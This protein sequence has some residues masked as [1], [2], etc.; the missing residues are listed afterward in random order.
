MSYLGLPDSMRD[1]NDSEL[2]ALDEWLHPW[3]SQPDGIYGV[4]PDGSRDLKTIYEY[5]KSKRASQPQPV[6]AGQTY[7]QPALDDDNIPF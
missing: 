4:S 5:L 3:Y 2:I 6:A 1:A 7:T